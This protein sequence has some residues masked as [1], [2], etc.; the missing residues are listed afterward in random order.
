MTQAA[1]TMREVVQNPEQPYGAYVLRIALIS[2]DIW[3]SLEDGLAESIPSL[4]Y[5]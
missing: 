5:V 1:G 4:I 3:I 2:C